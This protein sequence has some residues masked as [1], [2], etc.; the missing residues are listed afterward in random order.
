MWSVGV[1]TY[2]RWVTVKLSCMRVFVVNLV[3]PS[4]QV[5]T[6]F[7][8]RGFSVAAPS[9]WNSLPS[10]ILNFVS[11]L[12]HSAVFLKPTVSSRFSV[13]SSGSHKCLRFG[14]CL[15]LHTIND[16]ICLRTYL[17]TFGNLE[18]KLVTGW[19]FLAVIQQTG[20]TKKPRDNNMWNIDSQFGNVVCGGRVLA[21]V[22]RSHLTRTRKSRI[23]SRMPASC[24]PQILGVKFQRKVSR[25][26][27]DWYWIINFMLL[28]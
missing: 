3:S 20:N 24:I 6:T 9:L 14:L 21:W 27:V 22:E 23:R 5:H 13:S 28:Y 10:G 2:V 1:I 7:A 12:T 17:V 4:P 18:L 16:F 25:I 15:T 8:S 11:H 19:L 26:E